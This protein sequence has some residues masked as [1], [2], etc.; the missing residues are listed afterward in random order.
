VAAGWADLAE[1]NRRGL[2]HYNR[3]RRAGGGDDELRPV[4]AEFALRA[5]LVARELRSQ[6]RSQRCAEL[7]AGSFCDIIVHKPAG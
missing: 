3:R 2:V 5:R 7:P 4:L 6:D 1:R